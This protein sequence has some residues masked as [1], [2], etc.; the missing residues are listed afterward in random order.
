M[1][2]ALRWAAGIT[3]LIVLLAVAFVVFFDWSMLR[4]ALAER[5]TD[6]LGR[7]FVIDGRMDGRLGLQPRI[8][9]R[10]IR[11]ANAD[12][13]T[14]PNMVEIESLQIRVDLRSL[15]RGSLVFPSLQVRGAAVYLETDADGR[16]N[17]D[18]N[19]DRDEPPWIPLIER[20]VIEDSRLNIVD[21]RHEVE[22]DTII[23]AAEA[24]SPERG[25]QPVKADASGRFQ[26]EAFDVAMRG[27]SLVDLRA[28]DEPYPL[29]VEVQMGST[30][31][32]LTGSVE[33]PFRPTDVVM[34]LSIKG[35]NLYLLA[36]VLQLPFPSTRPYELSGDFL[37][38]G[39]LW[40]F[41]DFSGTVGDSDLAGSVSLDVG[42]E[43]PLMVADLVSEH[44]ELVD[45]G[46]LIGLNPGEPTSG[47]TNEEPPARLL[48]DAPLQREQIQ[49]VDARVTFRGERVIAP[50]LP[51]R[52]VELDL[53]LED[54][55]LKLT[56]LRFGLAGGTGD[57]FASIYST[58]EPAHS[59]LD[60]RLSG[61]QLQAFFDEV[62]LEGA[63]E[64][65]IEGRAVFA[66]RG[67]TIRSAM[68]S[69]EGEAALVMERGKIDGSAL[70]L[71]DA[72]FLEALAVIIG[73]GEPETMQIRC[74]VAGLDIHEGVT[75]TSAMILDTERTLISGEG[76]ADLRAETLSLRLEGQPKDPGIAHSRVPVEISGH[77][78][79]LALEIDPS[80]IV[81]RGGLALGL[82]ALFAP[83]AGILPFIDPGLAE[84][85]D[86]LQLIDEEA[87]E[88][89]E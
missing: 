71:L 65:V 35:P 20:L 14:R 24:T 46:P 22:F 25:E 53:D 38:T 75:S 26:G 50:Q 29:E 36:P 78:T 43:Q 83:L 56:P 73:N 28:Q 41:D 33:R 89:L 51:F 49:K 85:S 63:A 2:S 37:R 45:L 76:E 4:S 1:R 6:E 80:G 39:D 70:A 8:E 9:A 3:V 59:D 11:L 44:L 7:E 81:V 77:V 48:P 68:G 64:G 52:D 42:R 87:G 32:V 27:A 88:L 60:L 54:G 15:A 86:C 69:A 34:A 67:D 31:L 62:G 72:G 84:D 17:W 21:H 58:V 57:L 16:S 23:A 10:D 40:R 19:R 55:V 61:I 5:L 66:T 47:E 79:A 82:G 18:L 12:W 30:E 13:G 74:F